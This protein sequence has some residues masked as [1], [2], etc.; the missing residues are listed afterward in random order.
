MEGTRL[1]LKDL[2]VI[3]NGRAGLADGFLWLWMPGITMQQAAVFV[4]NPDV[5]GRII[6]QYG[7]EESV[8]AGYIVCKSLTTDNGETVVCMVKG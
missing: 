7:E 6:F 5:M 8:Y 4:F 1:F 3:E 2:T